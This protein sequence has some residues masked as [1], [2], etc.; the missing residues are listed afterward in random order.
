[1][2]AWGSILLQDTTVNP[3]GLGS[4]ADLDPVYS[5]NAGSLFILAVGRQ[6]P[7]LAAKR[8]ELKDLQFP[9]VF[10]LTSD[11]L[12]FPYTQDAWLNS[13]NSKDTVALTA[14][15]SP[16]KKLSEPSYKERFGFA[17]SDPITFAGKLSR[18]E[19]KM[20]VSDKVQEALYTAEEVKLL[21]AV[22]NGLMQ[23]EKSGKK[24]SAPVTREQLEAKAQM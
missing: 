9:L 7:P 12:I 3:Y 17:L 23:N 20:R 19:A 1:M 24:G 16:S 8:L 4:A 2:I 6:G 21:E 22:D 18:S 11:D 13:D 15:V 5:A 14:I 10:E